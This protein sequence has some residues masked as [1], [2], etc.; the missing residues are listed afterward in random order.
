MS[1]MEGCSVKIAVMISILSFSI[2]GIVG[3]YLYVSG[4]APESVIGMLEDILKFFRPFDPITVLFV[5]VKNLVAVFIMW[6]LGFFFIV[7]SLISL[8]FNGYLIGYTITYLSLKFSL[9]FALAGILPH[10]IFELPALILS[11][12][13]GVLA[14]FSTIKKIL[15][16]LGKRNW[17]FKYGVNQS[18]KL[19][20]FSII[21]LI[22]AAIIEVYV[23]PIILR[24]FL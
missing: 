2:G 23:T 14:G 4:Y 1:L 7:P 10:G 22:P 12:T 15:A 19:I 13:A 11:G 18:F 16:V 24:F 5:Y 21:L 8:G 3:F 20:K 9:F 17:S 6:L